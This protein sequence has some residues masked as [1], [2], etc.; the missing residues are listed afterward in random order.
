MVNFITNAGT[1][2]TRKAIN[3]AGQGFRPGLTMAEDYDLYLRMARAG[4]VI[5]AVDEEHVSYRKHSLATTANGNAEL[6]QAIMQVRL[7]NQVTPFPLEA[8][9]AHALPDLSSK[10][11]NDPSQRALWTDDR[12]TN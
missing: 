2:F 9:R 7:L 3:S 6:H 10:L 12:W 4:V 11:L 8:I 1:A 5:Q